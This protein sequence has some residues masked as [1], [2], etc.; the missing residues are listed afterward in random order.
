[1]DPREPMI[2]RS[3]DSADLR[4]NSAFE[5]D[6]GLTSAELAGRPL[7]DW[8]HSDDREQLD[9]ALA[10]GEGSVRARHRTKRAEWCSLHWR[11]K[12]QDGRAFALGRSQ[13]G[14]ELSKKSPEV[15]VSLMDSTLTDT[16]EAMV[17]V[18][19]SKTSGLRCSILLLEP[20]SEIV[21]VGVGPSLPAEYNAAVEGLRIGPG[22]GSCG[23]AAFWNVPVIVEDIGV[24]PLWKDL[25]GAAAVAGVASCWS[26]PITASRDGRVLGA[27]ALYN[28]T[29]C[30]PLNGEMDILDMAA[31]MVGLAIERDGLEE[32]LR[33]ATKDDAIGV[34]AGGIAHDFNNLLA[35]IL[36][37]DELAMA[38]LATD[39]EA[40]FSLEQIVD[41]ST[42]AGE[43]CSQLLAY[44]GKNSRTAENVDC[45]AL[46]REISSILKAGFSSKVTLDF[47]LHETPL[48]IVADR[49]QM[50]QVI[51]NL[52]TNASDA[53]GRAEGRVVVGT[54][55]VNLDPQAFA[56]RHPTARLAG[57]ETVRLW[58]S[59][60]GCGMNPDT[61]D[62]VF[63]PF[64][65]TKSLGRGLGLA[66]VQ[67]IV[68]G[69]GG[70]IKV[71]ST[72]GEGTTFSV[73][74]PRARLSCEA[75]VVAPKSPRESIRACILVADDEQAVRQ[76]FARILH[77]AGYDVL[78][79]CDGQEAVDIF[80]R[81]SST[82]DAVLM[83]LGMPKL[84]G[85]EAFAQ[86][87][88]IRSD[89]RVVLISGY[90]E[91]EVLDRFRG[92]RLS[93]VIQKPALKEE[94]LVA[95]AAALK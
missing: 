10:A 61:Q 28:T 47:E 57:G 16:L 17:R 36:G 92:V 40:R 85:A 59:D 30:A 34:L 79:A 82:I 1:M 76:V 94:L 73:L 56:L 43:L 4:I 22:V 31:R 39:T 74:L 35:A 7:L 81:E 83:D 2:L 53:L 12:T 72:L 84:D 23:T 18:V 37:N 45:S 8:I 6:L 51:M 49:S 13:G 63:D 44:A 70:V 91:Q 58:V 5:N 29:P 24:D 65:T 21:S 26:V 14:P 64:F 75:P 78:E 86:I 50:R 3:A 89:A 20:G 11:V 42:A 32:Q 68:R 95:M 54:T 52:I 87:R 55:L 19:E 38:S 25:R 41:A 9:R 60:T 93:G 27:M 46:V 80:R 48:D 66:A 69:H 67:G 62:K 77:G 90:A 15:G 71:E 33:S 88:E